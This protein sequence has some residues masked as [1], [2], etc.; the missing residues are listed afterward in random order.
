MAK[1]IAMTN[2]LLTSLVPQQ[3][4]NYRSDLNEK[5]ILHIPIYCNGKHNLYHEMNND[6]WTRWTCKYVIR[7]YKL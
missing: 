4:K 6:W 2:C 1:P 5:I 3:N 7:P